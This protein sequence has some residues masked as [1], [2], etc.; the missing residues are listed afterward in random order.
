AILEENVDD[1]IA[2]LEAGNINFDEEKVYGLSV[3]EILLLTCKTGNARLVEELLK[4]PSFKRQVCNYSD[5]SLLETCADGHIEMVKALVAAGAIIPEVKEKD[6]EKLL[7]DACLDGDL[8]VVE[9]VLATGFK[10]FD[11]MWLTN[12]A[13][14]DESPGIL[15]SLLKAIP[16]AKF[17]DK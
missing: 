2:I 5:N 1:V 3:Q 17:T 11:T 14:G 4:F 13:I 10:A 8:D 9:A 16:E 7:R 6:F 15:T 12:I